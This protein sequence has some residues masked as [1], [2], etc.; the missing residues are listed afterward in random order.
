MENNEKLELFAA[1]AM[2]GLLANPDGASGPE[3]CAADAVAHA[4][5]LLEELDK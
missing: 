4:K 3:V 5:K 1:M 2:I